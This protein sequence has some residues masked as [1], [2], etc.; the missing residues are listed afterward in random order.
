MSYD[1][2]KSKQGRIKISTYTKYKSILDKWLIPYFTSKDAGKIT[3]DN[4]ESLVNHLSADGL[5]ASYINMIPM[6]LNSIIEYSKSNGVSCDYTFENHRLAIKK[7]TVNVL[8]P[9]HQQKLTACLLNSP[10]STNLGILLSLYMGLR[11]GEVCALRWSEVMLDE[12]MIVVRQTVQR[13]PI[14][15]IESKTALIVGEPKSE[16]SCR[17]IPIPD[18][19]I[20][21]L[22]KENNNSDC[23]LLTGTTKPFDP[24]SMQNRFKRVLLECGISDTNFHVLRH[25]FATRCVECGI[26][27]KT[28]SELLG[29]SS[30]K[31]TLDR[32]VHPTQEQKKNSINKLANFILL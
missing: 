10:T 19:I 11:L 6:L 2:L 15:S 18:F 29:H 31:I 28:L 7:N 22:K 8:S 17:S 13:L 27:V 32:Y 24:R 30:V 12:G 16:G 5:S 23:Y 3:H 26:D 25:T 9:E 20:Q 1:W 4:V 14:D 21:I